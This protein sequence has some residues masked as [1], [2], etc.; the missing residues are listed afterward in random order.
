MTKKNYPTLSEF[1]SEHY[2]EV[3]AAKI[4]ASARE[5]FATLPANR[6]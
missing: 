2:S 6:S 1:I 5:E 3:E 4:R